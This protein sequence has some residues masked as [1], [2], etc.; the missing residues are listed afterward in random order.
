MELEALSEVR[1]I[2]KSHEES[3]MKTMW[4]RTAEETA[5]YQASVQ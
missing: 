4:S 3:Q 2:N 5:C 1:R